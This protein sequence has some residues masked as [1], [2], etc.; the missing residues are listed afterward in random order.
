[1]Q[2]NS[3]IGC[4]VGLIITNLV[5]CSVDV[6]I[7]LLLRNM[8]L[9]FSNANG[10]GAFGLCGLFK[11]LP[12]VAIRRGLPISFVLPALIE[13]VQDPACLVKERLTVGS[14]VYGA[15]RSNCDNSCS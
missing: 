9:D 6:A 11:M 4:V 8:P 12:E 10:P 13:A 14:N 1:M 3:D 5:A 7:D 2:L 15:V